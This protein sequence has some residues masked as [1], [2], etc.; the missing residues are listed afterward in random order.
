MDG[1]KQQV[2]RDITGI[3][4]DAPP[5]QWLDFLKL[6]RSETKPLFNRFGLDVKIHLAGHVNTFSMVKN[7]CIDIT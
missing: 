2:S 3:V 5:F 1:F 6:H 7:G 4:T